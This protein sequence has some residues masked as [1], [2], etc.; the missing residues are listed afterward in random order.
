MDTSD[1]TTP[2]T[3][4]RVSAKERIVAVFIMA[5]LAAVA[6]LVIER[7]IRGGWRSLWSV[8]STTLL[9]WIGLL[10]YAVIG[11]Q[12]SPKALGIGA[13]YGA[14]IGLVYGVLVKSLLPGLVGGV[15]IGH[16]VGMLLHLR[17]FQV[18]SFRTKKALWVGGAV[19]GAIVACHL[20][21]VM[22]PTRLIRGDAS[23]AE[24]AQGAASQTLTSDYFPFRDG[25]QAEYEIS[26]AL[27]MTQNWLYLVKNGTQYIVP[28]AVVTRERTVR[29]TLSPF[30][31]RIEGKDVVLS[32]DNKVDRV[33][34]GDA[35]VGDEW[36]SGFYNYVFIGFEDFEYR[37]YE[38]GPGPIACAV[39]KVDAVVDGSLVTSEKRFYAKGVGMVGKAV[40][41]KDGQLTAKW[42]VCRVAPTVSTTGEDRFWGK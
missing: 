41:D 27:A 40:Y 30:V 17:G 32:K 13:G 7:V 15:C 42:T 10:P 35:K 25:A 19:A 23:R 6:L 36:S 29:K 16:C 26:G 39:I 4:S 21:G 34:K 18:D 22:K 5:I 33:I 31:Y 14:A 1:N 8:F 37:S 28:E 11:N 24:T 9:L 3:S 38:N 12:H 2:D 20:V